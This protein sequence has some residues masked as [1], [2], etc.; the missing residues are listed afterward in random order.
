LVEPE[1]LTWL[2]AA[3]PR[4][5]CG[6]P[7]GLLADVLTPY[8]GW[9]VKTACASF[10]LALPA[11]LALL[12]EQFRHSFVAPIVVLLPVA[13]VLGFCSLGLAA[14]ATDIPSGRRRIIGL[15]SLPAPLLGLG[16][17]VSLFFMPPS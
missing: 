4:R 8:A 6:G 7:L 11:Y 5:E 10:A 1:S 16:I 12:S 2:T 15:L 3:L 13:A 9:G 14:F 17:V